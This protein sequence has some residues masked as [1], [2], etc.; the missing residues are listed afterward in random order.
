[1]LTTKGGFP[2]QFKKVLSILSLAL[3]ATLPFG[4]AASAADEVVIGVLYPL[5]GPVA[6]VGID[7]VAALE[8]AVEIINEQSDLNLP[9]AK[10]KGL[11]SV[12]R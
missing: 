12:P 3:L 7:A 11:P 2:M 1:M 9:L 4:R 6:Q 5:S 8:T 10:G